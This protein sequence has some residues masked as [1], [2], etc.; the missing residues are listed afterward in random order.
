MNSD[1]NLNEL[2][3][4]VQ[5]Y[6]EIFRFNPYLHTIDKTLEY[7]REYKRKGGKRYIHALD[8]RLKELS[9]SCGLCGSV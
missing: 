9:P 7:Y 1:Y 6:Y 5:Y 8:K 2:W 4:N 3:Q